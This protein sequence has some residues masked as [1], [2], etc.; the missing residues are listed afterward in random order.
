MPFIHAVTGYSRQLI[1]R[2]SWN[3][4][5]KFYSGLFERFGNLFGVTLYLEE[6]S[7]III[8]I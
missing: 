5:I 1:V 8:F 7:G 3:A 4:Y 6:H 2:N